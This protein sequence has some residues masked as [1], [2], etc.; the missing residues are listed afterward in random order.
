MYKNI[1]AVSIDDNEQNLMLLEAFADQIELKVINFSDPIKAFEFI[2]TNEVDII[3]TDY[4]MPNMNGLELIEQFRKTNNATPIIM[5]T[6]AGEDSREKALEI[7]ATDF[8]NK[9]LDLSEF[10]VRTKNLLSLRFA[11][12]QLQNRAKQLEVEVQKA[13]EDLIDRE[14]ES[15]VVLGKTAEFKDPET[16]NHIARVAHYSKLLANRYGLD[17]ATQEIIYYASPFHDIGKVGIKDNILLKPGKLDDDEFDIMKTHAAIGYSIL[18]DAKSKYLKMGALIALTH[19]EKYNGKG[20]PKGLSGDNIP[21]EG[22]IVA[23]ADVFDA[24]VSIRPYKKAWSFDD[25]LELLKKESG[26]HFDPELVTLFVENIDD[27]KSI[28]NNFQES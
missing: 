16:A 4:M 17:K 23:I 5:V 1:I 25:A 22:R 24:L 13:T 15:L 19:H 14:H 11:Q 9:P 27:I 20:Y 6:A 26:E 28:Y 2:T 12:I 10:I 7:G 18:K 3:F 21:I 8:L